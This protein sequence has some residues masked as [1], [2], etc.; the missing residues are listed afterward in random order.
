MTDT[1]Y[2]IEITAGDTTMGIKPIHANLQGIARAKY[3]K[4]NVEPDIDKKINSSV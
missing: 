4:L 2:A 3:C 1:K